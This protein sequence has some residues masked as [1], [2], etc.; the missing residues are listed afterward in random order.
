MKGKPRVKK[1]KVTTEE[2]LAGVKKV[3]PIIIKG[4]P[5]LL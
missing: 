4:Y 1:D 2:F 3:E 5:K